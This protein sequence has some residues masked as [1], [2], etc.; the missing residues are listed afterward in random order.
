MTQLLIVDDEAHVV[1]RLAAMVPWE[2]V[3][4][5]AVHKAYSGMEAL[6][7]LQEHPIDVVLTDVRMPGMTGLELSAHIRRNWTKTRCILLSGHAD[8]EYAKEAISSGLPAICLSPLK[9]KS[10][11]LLSTMW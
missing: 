5:A 2:S 11:S 4:V 6:E 9:T 1:E 10:C 3:G 8:F 7:L